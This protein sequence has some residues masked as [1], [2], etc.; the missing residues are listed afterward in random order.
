MAKQHQVRLM[1]AVLANPSRVG[2]IAAVLSTAA[3][4]SG[5]TTMRQPA[6]EV[7]FYIHA[8]FDEAAAQAMLAPGNNA[9]KGNAFMRQKGGGVVTCA[10]SSVYLTPATAYAI[11]RMKL[12]YGPVDSGYARRI[13]PLTPEPPAYFSTGRSE[14]CDAQ[15][16]FVFADLAD[17]DFF[18]TTV[19]SWQVA[20]AQQGGALM[21]RVRLSGGRIVSIVMS[22]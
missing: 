18:I 11:E 22:S 17:G 5:C 8:N 2:L 1:A 3:A 13:P 15:G 7:P 12:V 20:S 9:I 14:K 10:G 6:A 19:V 4:L 21:Q 16:N